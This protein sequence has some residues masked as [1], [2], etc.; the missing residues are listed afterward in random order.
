MFQ[1]GIAEGEVDPSFGPLEALRL[2]VLTD[3][4]VWV[5]LS[6]VSRLCRCS[7]KTSAS[8]LCFGSSHSQQ[9]PPVGLVQ[10]YNVFNLFYSIHRSAASGFE[11]FVSVPFIFCLDIHQKSGVKVSRPPQS[12]TSD[13]RSRSPM[14][15]SL[16]SY[17]RLILWLHGD[18]FP[19]RS[20]SAI[21]WQDHSIAGQ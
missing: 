21:C 9:L 10:T 11:G 6:E 20:D 16:R 1:N 18:E 7:L 5:I 12:N 2:S 14:E 3:S 8:L 13:N 19:A 17:C 15:R 4:P